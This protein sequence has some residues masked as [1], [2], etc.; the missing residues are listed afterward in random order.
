M[1][2]V[3]AIVAALLMVAALVSCNQAKTDSAAKP[4]IKVASDTSFP[5]ME[6]VADNKDIVGFDIDLLNA[7]GEAEGFTP[8]FETVS[9]D[10]IFAALENGSFDMIASSVS[11]T[12]E[13]KQKYDFSDPYVTVGQVLVVPVADA[14]TTKMAD[15]AGKEIGVQIGTTGDQA[16]QAAKVVKV[17][18]FPEI[19]LAF[20]DLVNGNLAGLLIDSPVAADY[21]LNNANFKGK[22]KIVGELV[23][24]E[25]YGYTLKKG[26]ADLLAKLNKGIADLT[27]NGKLAE[28]K[29]KWALK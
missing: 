6:F 15:L 29:A 20:Q 17:K 5:P 9:W 18:G 22:V 1:K 11:I 2:N 24:S 28:L 19:G 7:I 21:A 10:G 12:D 23:T 14:K 27:A 4:V 25:P 26:N 16:A 13:R 3:V 8:K